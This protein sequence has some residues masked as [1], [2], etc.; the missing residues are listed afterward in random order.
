MGYSSVFILLENNSSI[1]SSLN[2]FQVFAILKAM[3]NSLHETLKQLRKHRGISQ[4]ELADHFGYKSFTTIQ[5]WE[6]GSSLPPTK[7]LSQLA[8]YYHVSLEDLL[9]SPRQRPVPILG[10]VR[11]GP[12]RLAEQEFSGIEYIEPSEGDPDNHFYLEVI[13]DSMIHA[14]ILPGDLVYVRR[15][16]TLESGDIAVVL[17]GDEATVKRVFFKNNALILHPENP[18]YAD[19]VFTDAECESKPVRIL[20]KVI[21]IKI[22]V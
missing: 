15:Q 17:V 7:L 14:R 5:K 20:G 8:A 6:D 21:H 1:K 19:V 9:G 18:R 3:N 2:Y 10:T 11:G 16:T 12:L 4:Q 22:K 13:G